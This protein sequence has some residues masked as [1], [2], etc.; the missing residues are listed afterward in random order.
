LC[1]GSSWWKSLERILEIEDE[2]EG[3]EAS[4]RMV[5]EALQMLDAMEAEDVT[6]QAG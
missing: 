6:R 2:A 4:R 1:I 5:D 3:L